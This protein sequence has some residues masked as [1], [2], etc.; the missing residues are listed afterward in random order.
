VRRRPHLL[1]Y[2]VDLLDKRGSG[3]AFGEAG[4]DRWRVLEL[5]LQVAQLADEIAGQA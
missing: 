2:G 3:G 4:G 1:V 5:A